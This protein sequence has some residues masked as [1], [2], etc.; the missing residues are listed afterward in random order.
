[1]EFG[2][3]AAAASRVATASTTRPHR[4]QARFPNNAGTVKLMGSGAARAALR[5]QY[6][7]SAVAYFNSKRREAKQSSPALP[8]PPA[9]DLREAS[10]KADREPNESQSASVRVNPGCTRW[11]LA[12]RRR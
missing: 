5:G 8:S 10:S 4:S 2:A 1:M 3:A 11:L 7:S 6:L 12:S 9:Q